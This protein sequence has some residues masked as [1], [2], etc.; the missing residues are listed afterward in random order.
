MVEIKTIGVVKNGFNDLADPFEMRKCISQIEIDGAYADGLYRLDE[1]DEIQVIFHFHKSTSF[2][3]RH[4]NYFGEYKG[5]FAACSPN[6]PGSIGVTTVKLLKIEGCILT[7]TGLD[8]INETPVLDIKPAFSTFSP[9][10]RK[11]ADVAEM[12]AFPRKKLIPL[13]KNNDMEALLLEAGLIHGHYCPGLSMGVIAGVVGMNHWREDSDGLEDIVAIAEVNSCMVDGIQFVTGCSMG[14]NGLIYR[15]FGKTAVTFARRSTDKGI[16]LSLKPD[17][18]QN[19]KNDA[20]AFAELFTRVIVNQNREPQLVK[21]FKG[22]STQASFNLL[23]WPVD[24]VFDRTPVTAAIPDYAPIRDSHICEVCNESY[25][26]IKAGSG[27]RC[28][29]CSKEAYH[30]LDGRGIS[31]IPQNG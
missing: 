21:E 8:A 7:V 24:K 12:K 2:E 5:V 9:E 6:R 18:H 4:V 28:L 19:L 25:M 31:L 10:K 26:D 29:S 14:N 13:I 30:Q 15:D 3:L 23:K 1:C 27:N 20:P 11:A 22:A 16:R 17:F